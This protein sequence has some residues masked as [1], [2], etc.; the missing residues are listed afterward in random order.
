MLQ[1]GAS[2]FHKC[3]QFVCFFTSLYHAYL[4]T[5]HRRP[6]FAPGVEVILRNLSIYYVFHHFSQFFQSTAW[7]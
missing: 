6:W 2:N 7:P 5:C 1:M 3:T 4:K